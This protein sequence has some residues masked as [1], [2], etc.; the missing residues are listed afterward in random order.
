M[1]NVDREQDKLRAATGFLRGKARPTYPSRSV[2]VVQQMMSVE[3][4]NKAMMP[5]ELF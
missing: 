4:P 1:D 5:L 2:V 3:R